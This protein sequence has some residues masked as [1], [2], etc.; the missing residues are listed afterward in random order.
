MTQAVQSNKRITA[1]RASASH[2]NPKAQYALG[3]LYE[4]GQGLKKNSRHAFQWY[5]KA[6]DQGLPE[7]QT[8]LGRF[9]AD[10][11]GGMHDDR[12]AV[13]WYHLA[14]EQNYPEA[15]YHLAEIYS[16]GRGLSKK[17]FMQAEYWYGRAAEL[18]HGLSAWALAAHYLDRHPKQAL[19]WLQ[20]AAEQGVKEAQRSLAHCYSVGKGVTK[21]QGMAMQW[22]TA[23]AKRGDPIALWQI[24]RHFAEQQDFVKARDCYRK[25]GEYGL[26]AAQSAL[27]LLYADGL[28]VEKN[29]RL[30]AACFNKAAEQEDAEA[31]HN[32]ALLYLKGEG[33]RRNIQKAM[34]FFERAARL[35]VMASRTWLGLLH[36]QGDTGKV[37]LVEASK[38]F[39]AAGAD[40]AAQK[41]LAQAVSMMKRPEIAQ[42]KRLTKEW[43]K[44]IPKS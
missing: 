36:A 4:S 27:G 15:Q 23:A 25:A 20:L 28:G 17:D 12:E 37:D 3:V 5:S 29:Y 31:L 21:N 44:A 24:G 43:L 1:L 6:A 38:W 39:I 26:A 13:Q 7:A 35:G 34:L 11:G 8:A 14:A 30:A 33:V 9:Y 42:A 2:G 40:P 10:S 22:Y 16:L 18:G 19:H 41:N 32:L